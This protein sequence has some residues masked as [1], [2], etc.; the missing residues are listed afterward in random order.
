[1]YLLEMQNSRV[2]LIIPRV[3]LTIILLAYLHEEISAQSVVLYFYIYI[4][5]SEK[6]SYIFGIRQEPYIKGNEETSIS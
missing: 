4:Y 5:V 3:I 1:M 2:I 6:I